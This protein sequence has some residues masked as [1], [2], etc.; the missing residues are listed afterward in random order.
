MTKAQYKAQMSKAGVTPAIADMFNTLYDLMVDIGL[1]VHF[2]G[3]D[4]QAKSHEITRIHDRLMTNNPVFPDS[5]DVFTAYAAFM[6]DIA[7][8]KVTIRDKSV[9]GLS[10]AFKTW[11]ASSEILAEI[12]RKSAPQFIDLDYPANADIKRLATYLEDWPDNEIQRQLSII[13]MIGFKSIDFPGVSGY[14]ARIFREAEKRNLDPLPIR[15]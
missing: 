6:N 11:L 3:M 14:M 8:G 1:G 15:R 12:Q 4:K 2:A 9:M 5:L 13:H 10:S 7:Y